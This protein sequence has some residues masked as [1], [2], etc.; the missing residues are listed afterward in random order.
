ML[1]GL[2]L[3]LPDPIED[4]EGEKSD[5]GQATFAFTRSVEV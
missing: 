2:L 1:G 5:P 3:A 4:A